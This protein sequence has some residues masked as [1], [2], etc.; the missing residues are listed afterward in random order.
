[1]PRKQRRKGYWRSADGYIRIKDMDDTHLTNAI[2][3]IERKVTEIHRQA[4][5]DAGLA[6][7]GIL[8][9]DRPRKERALL[10]AIPDPAEMFPVYTELKE[11]QKSRYQ[12]YVDKAVAK[13][14]IK[15]SFGS[16]RRVIRHG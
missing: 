3:L 6:Q 9:I 8:D 13:V 15:D 16:S 2:G 4:I 10:D 7:R 12:N 14:E 5:F 11:E 1:M